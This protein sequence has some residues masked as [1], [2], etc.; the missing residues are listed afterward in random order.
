MVHG[1]DVP[2]SSEGSGE[3]IV[4]P[5]GVLNHHPQFCT[6]GWVSLVLQL[7]ESTPCNKVS[8]KFVTTINLRC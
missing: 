3:D 7:Q 4:G 6:G 1:L 8:A 5:I 2:S